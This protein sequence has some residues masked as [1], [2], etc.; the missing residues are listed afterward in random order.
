M[1]P[2]LSL[3]YLLLSYEDLLLVTARG[4]AFHLMSLIP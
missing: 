1:L 4:K 2:L 3:E